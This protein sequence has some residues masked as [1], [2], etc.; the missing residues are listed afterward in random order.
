MMCSRQTPLLINPRNGGFTLLEVL[1]VL[2]ILGLL[3]AMVLPAM[4][5]LDDRARRRITQERMD[6]IRRAILGPEDRFDA[7]GR[8][9]I[10]GYVGDMRAWPDLWE[11]RAEIKPHFGGTGWENPSVHV[12]RAWARGR[13]I[14]VDRRT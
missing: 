2:F 14:T 8:P 12:R 10:G 1:I 4:G 9:V 5:V 3:A 7:Q 6:L 11:A 13:I